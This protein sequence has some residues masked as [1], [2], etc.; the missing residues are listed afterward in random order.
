M[1]TCKD[2]KKELINIS[3][4]QGNPRWQLTLGAK[5]NTS[6]GYNFVILW[7]IIIVI[8]LIKRRTTLLD[9]KLC[10]DELLNRIHEVCQ[11]YRN[12]AIE[13]QK[14]FIMMFDPHFLAKFNLKLKKRCTTKSTYIG[15]QGL[16]Y[17]ADWRQT[18][19]LSSKHTTAVLPKHLM[20][21]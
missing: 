11:D 19:C 13:W 20:V 14:Y 7:Y 5:S 15:L 8:Y 21:L 18:H 1:Q 4:N 3:K 10:L 9:P 12:R 2:P 17:L 16:F 6:W